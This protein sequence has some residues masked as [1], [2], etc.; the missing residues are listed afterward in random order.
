MVV[1]VL[2]GRGRILEPRRWSVWGTVVEL[3]ITL[4][5]ILD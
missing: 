3:V 2:G 1:V 5:S 4:P